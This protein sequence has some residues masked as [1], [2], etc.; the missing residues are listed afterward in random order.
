MMELKSV[1]MMKFPTEWKIKIH[2]PNHQA[3]MYSVDYTVDVYIFSTCPT[4]RQRLAAQHTFNTN[5]TKS[6]NMGTLEGT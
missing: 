1:G 4:S 3:E 6:V 5:R 2:V